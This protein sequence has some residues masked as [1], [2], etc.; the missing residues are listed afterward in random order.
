MALAV[1]TKVWGQSS[2]FPSNDYISPYDTICY[3]KEHLHYLIITADSLRPAFKDFAL[4]KVLK[5]YNVKITAVEDIYQNYSTITD[6]VERIK[7][8]IAEHY[9][10]KNK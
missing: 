5:G 6:S 1:P 9:M 2:P 10:E 8:Y 4:S 7:W 3:D